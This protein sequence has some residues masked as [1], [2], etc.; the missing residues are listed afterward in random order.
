MLVD[1]IIH[2][3]RKFD[4]INYKGTLSVDNLFLFKFFI[5]G[6]SDDF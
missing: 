5:N 2:D 4:K 6:I 1:K 3:E